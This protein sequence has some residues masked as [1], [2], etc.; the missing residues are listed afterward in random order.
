MNG[1]MDSGASP[2]CGHAL[3][4]SRSLVAGFLAGS[5]VG[6]GLGWFFAPRLSALGHQTA[7]SLQRIG[8][9]ATDRYHEAG[10]RLGAVV[11]EVTA[12]GQDLRDQVSDAVIRGAKDV[13][14]FAEQSK[15]GRGPQGSPE[16]DAVGSTSERRS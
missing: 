3:D 1:Q 10:G 12:K 13:E 2:E 16:A 6:A 9:A 8:A 4:R 7:E 15:S 11:D 14:R 5:V